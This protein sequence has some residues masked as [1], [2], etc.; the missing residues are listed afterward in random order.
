[1]RILTVVSALLLSACGLKRMLPEGPVLKPDARADQ[2]GELRESGAVYTSAPASDVPVIPVMVWGVSYDLDLVLVTEHPE[3]DMTEIARI[4]TPTGPIWMAK[5]ARRSDL[6]QIIVADIPDL[7]TW[8]P[9]I[10]IERVRSSVR[11]EDRSTET[12][13]D[14]DIFYS[15]PDGE[16]VHIS[17]QG[18]APVAEQSKR[19]GSTM[20]HSK[21][22]VIAVLDLPR[23]NLARTASVRINGEPQKV[24]KIAGLVPFAM[25]LTQT[26]AGMAVADVQMVPV[27]STFADAPTVDVHITHQLPEGREATQTWNIGRGDSATRLIQRSEA[28][29]IEHRF[30]GTESLEWTGAT[31]QQAGKDEPALV[32]SANPALPDLRRRFD[33][34]MVSRFVMDVAGQESHATGELH[35]EWVGDEVVV[36]VRPD[37]P[38]WVAERPMDSRIQQT[39]DGISLRT[40]RV[41]GE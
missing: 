37:A 23:R 7:F 15:N 20:G 40:E 29:T 5:D 3:W 4:D 22:S 13:L 25:A 27:P 8:M 6:E 17:Y 39:E 34:V 1:M 2:F 9:E 36:R 31:V 16:P 32:I 18:S 26:Q 12:D 10:P 11:I 38:W 35:A 33:G 14:M 28:R 30:A 24:T 19:N 41:P 21:G